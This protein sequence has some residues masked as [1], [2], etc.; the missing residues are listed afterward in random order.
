M[1]PAMCGGGE[2]E[3][4]EEEWNAALINLLV[5]KDGLLNYQIRDVLLMKE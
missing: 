5:K 1:G 4:E 3:E 2:E